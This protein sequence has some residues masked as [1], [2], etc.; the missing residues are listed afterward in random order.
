MKK[1]DFNFDDI[2]KLFIVA[3]EL[4]LIE[5]DDLMK[6]FGK[7]IMLAYDVLKAKQ[8]LEEGDYGED[9]YSERIMDIMYKNKDKT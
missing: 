2:G 3:E 7:D 5:D 1:E 6:S 9:S 4:L 8:M